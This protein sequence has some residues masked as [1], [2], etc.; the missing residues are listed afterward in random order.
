MHAAPIGY[1]NKA[2][3]L[4]LINC[5]FEFFFFYFS[6]IPH[7]VPGVT[8]DE[9]KIHLCRNRS[10]NTPHKLC[11]KN[12]YNNNLFI[13]LSAMKWQYCEEENCSVR[14]ETSQ[15]LDVC[16]ATHCSKN[17][18][19]YFVN[20]LKPNKIVGF[21]ND[22][23]VYKRRMFVDNEVNNDLVKKVKVDKK[24]DRIMLKLMFE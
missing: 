22:F 2:V 1:S 5:I 7:L 21:P 18:L 6:T 20:Y 14:N 11:T 9:T 12:Y 8:N 4:I 23:N 13:H 19:E 16:F 10:E 17:E 24:V 3:T 15:R